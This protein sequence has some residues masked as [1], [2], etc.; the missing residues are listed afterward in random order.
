M[1]IKVTILHNQRQFWGLPI[2]VGFLSVQTNAS[3]GL[4]AGATGRYVIR[5]TET[6]DLHLAWAKQEKILS[7]DNKN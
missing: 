6:I 1:S 7:H 5:F 3:L 2:R 4:F